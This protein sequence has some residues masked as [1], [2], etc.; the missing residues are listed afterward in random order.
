MFFFE[1]SKAI[2]TKMFQN[3]NNGLDEA[4]FKWLSLNA[5]RKI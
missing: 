2:K 3:E 4:I 5:Y 1:K